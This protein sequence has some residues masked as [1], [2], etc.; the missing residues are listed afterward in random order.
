MQKEKQNSPNWWGDS[1]AIQYT[2]S[3]SRLNHTENLLLMA[4]PYTSPGWLYSESTPS[5]HEENRGANN[6]LV[7]SG[8][9]THFHQVLNEQ[10]KTGPKS[11]TTKEDEIKSMFNLNGKILI[12]ISSSFSVETSLIV[13]FSYLYI[14]YALAEINTF[15]FLTVFFFKWFFLSL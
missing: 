12:V 11:S 4:G 5:G 2:I 10:F 3:G 6:L 9:A 13:S 7:L 14:A 8:P 15:I 1:L